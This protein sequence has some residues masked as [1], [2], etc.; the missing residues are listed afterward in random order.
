MKSQYQDFSGY[1]LAG[2]KSSRMGQDKAFLKIDGK[3]FLH[4]SVGILNPICEDRIKIVLNPEQTDFIDRLPKN[5][6]HIFDT[7]YDRGPVGG[8]HAALKDCKTE[9]ALIIAVDQP[10]LGKTVIANLSRTALDSGA[11]VVIPKMENGRLQ[12][13][14]TIFRVESA[15]P[16]LE[17]LLSNETS[18][19][20]VLK[21]IESL[22]RIKL[23][24]LDEHHGGF[25]NINKPEDYRQINDD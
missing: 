4:N 16:T 25:D 3:T 13:L 23:F 7:Y 12:Q 8:I 15:F 22:E 5:V 18:S 6:A 24:E 20:S 19:V 1:I 10:L 14:C 17:K 11:D 9:F 2:G 21:F